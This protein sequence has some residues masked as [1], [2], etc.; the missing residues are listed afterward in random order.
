MLRKEMMLFLLEK[1]R[2]FAHKPRW[3][4]KVNQVPSTTMA[5]DR[6]GQMPTCAAE[7]PPLF[8]DDTPPL[9]SFRGLVTRR[10]RRGRLWETREGH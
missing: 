3:S 2:V 7:P 4:L 9:R 6:Q 8:H 5:S 1:V 10:P